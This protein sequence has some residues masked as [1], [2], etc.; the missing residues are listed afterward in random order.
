VGSVV[1]VVA[2]LP[3]LVRS[4]SSIGSL[5]PAPLL[6]L[7]AAAGWA[8]AARGAEARARAAARW[9]HG[10]ALVGVGGHVA[11]AYGIRPPS[12][13]SVGETLL[14][15][16]PIPI[17]IG[18]IL[19][20]SHHR[21]RVWS[22]GLV[23]DG[24]LLILAGLAVALRIV[25]EPMLA[26]GAMPMTGGAGMVV[27]RSMALVPVPAAAMIVLRRGS[28]L[29]PGSATLLLAATLAMAS[30]TL[31]GGTLTESTG[32]AA[33]GALLW[34]VAW[35]LFAASGYRAQL[36]PSTVA[37]MLA[38]RRRHDAIRKLVVPA[39]AL[40]LGAVVVDVAVGP[41]PRPETV[42]G[43]ALLAVVLAL[44]TAHAF[45]V[46]DRDAQQRRQLAYT[47]ALLDVTHALAG[48]TDVDE[49]LHVISESACKVFGTRGA[50]IELRS[51]DGQYL[52]T[53]SVVGMPR[54]VVGLRFPIEGSF[55]GWVVRHREARAS[56]DPSLDP[57]IQPQSLDFLGHSPVAAAPLVFRGEVLGALF[58]CI[59]PEPFEAEELELMSALAEQAALAI[60]QARLFEKVT[61][62]SVTDPLTGLANR[63]QLERELER[64]FAAACRGRS[65]IAV[66]FDLDDF[67][68]Y[69]DTYGHLAG[70]R[71]LRAFARSLEHETRA[72]N[73]AARYGGDE[74]VA[75]LAGTDLHGAQTFVERVRIRFDASVA[76]LGNGPITI[77]AGLAPHQTGMASPEA[78][79]RAADANLYSAKDRTRR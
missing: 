26:S 79:L 67:K 47:R 49:T 14:L 39:A 31:L 30:T 43:I 23:G 68:R 66:I 22:P 78:L 41:E 8:Q 71:A 45:S 70:D 54:S 55:T 20:L 35:A 63:R 69:N 36:V 27:L 11:M 5:L 37:E 13:V 64:E 65:L 2:L 75:L 17:S 38:G 24:L 58:A 44:R 60:Q 51:D 59:R 4:P 56:A 72:M 1:V 74:F 16:L 62:L 3:L 33:P 32:G 10:A 61:H 46:A 28:A 18:A 7:L 6:A 15:L 50:G 29:T 25:A 42:T 77:S 53:R 57:Y 52:E 76:T 9:F 48:K 12:G 19:A 34:L 21:S 73:F 40:C